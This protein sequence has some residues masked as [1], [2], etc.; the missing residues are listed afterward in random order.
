MERREFLKWVGIGIFAS[1]LPVLIAAC[2]SN[3]TDISITE[4]T[5]TPDPISVQTQD[6]F[7]PIGT[8]QELE[9][10]SFILDKKYNVIII[11]DQENGTIMALNPKCPHQGCTV[12]WKRDQNNLECPCHGSKFGTNGQLLQGPANE[13]LPIY[14]LKQ[15]GDSLLIKMS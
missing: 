9:K 11:R 2:S 5:Q 7:I 4:T 12:K 1:N 6:G 3:N 15:E 8:I 10:D 14:T 13:S